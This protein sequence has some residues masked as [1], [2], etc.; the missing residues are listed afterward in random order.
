[1][2][3]RRLT[4]IDSAGPMALVRARHAATEVG[5]AFRI[6]ESSPP[7]RRIAELTGLEDLLSDE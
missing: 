6:R 7:L 1:M 5:V 4:F 3:A 2:D